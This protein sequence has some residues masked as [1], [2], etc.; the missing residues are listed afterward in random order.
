MNDIHFNIDI[1]DIEE[2]NSIQ[3]SK[4]TNISQLYAYCIFDATQNKKDLSILPEHVRQYLYEHFDSYKQF[5]YKVK[6]RKELM[7]II[8]SSKPTADLNC[9]DISNITSLSHIFCFD[10]RLWTLFNCNI[11]KW[12]V[13][14]VTSL[15]SAFAHLKAFTGDISEWDVSN[16]EDMDYLFWKSDFN[17]DISKWNTSNVKNMGS[18]FNESKFNNDISEWDVS[19]VTNMDGIFYDSI[20]NKDISKWN[21][22]NVS[23]FISAF[24]K[25]KFN[26]D[27]SCWNISK[28]TTRIEN[29]FFDSI[30]E[31]KYKP[32]IN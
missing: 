4:Y 18:M 14:N 31:E 19:K 3:K 11:S 7:D 12:D 27:I 1:T 21:I 29:M 22:S 32:H 17:G 6:D 13:S 8:M 9:L 24:S 25:S 15:N 26:Q 16:V 5:Q 23:R 20:F 2:D 30:V 28:K 10:E